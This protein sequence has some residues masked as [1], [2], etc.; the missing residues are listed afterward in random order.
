[1][2]SEVIEFESN[3]G[4][5]KRVDTT[6]RSRPWLKSKNPLSEAV[7]REG[8]ACRAGVTEADI[9]HAHRIAEISAEAL[10]RYGRVKGGEIKLREDRPVTE[11]Y[12]FQS[13]RW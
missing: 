1:L 13:W 7:L 8:A 12:Q 3:N 4:K 11:P 2:L 6:Y 9:A 10:A 5:S